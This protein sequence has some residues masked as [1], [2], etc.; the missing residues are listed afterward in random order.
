MLYPF[1]SWVWKDIAAA[2][3]ERGQLIG[4]DISLISTETCRVVLPSSGF[5]GSKLLRQKLTKIFD[6]FM[7]HKKG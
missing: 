4:C 3:S 5:Q 6:I 2:Y 7:V 1:R